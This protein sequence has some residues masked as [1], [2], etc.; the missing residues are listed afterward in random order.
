M[1]VKFGDIN[2]WFAR[3][4]SGGV[5]FKILRRHSEKIKDI[6]NKLAHF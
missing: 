2:I 1:D 6:H 3:I 5:D 4:L